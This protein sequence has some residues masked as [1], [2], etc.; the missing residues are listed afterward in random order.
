[1]LMKKFGKSLVLSSF[2][3]LSGYAHANQDVPEQKA[4]SQPE[5]QT[6]EEAPQPSESSVRTDYTIADGNPYNLSDLSFSLIAPEG[7]ETV[8]DNGQLTMVI[9]E[10]KPK[11]SNENREEVIFQRNITVAVMHEASPIDEERAEKLEKQLSEQFGKNTLATNF[12]VLEHRFIDY[13][14]K[15]DAILVYSSLNIGEHPMMQMHLLVSSSNKQFLLT[16]TD[17]EK[18]FIEDK[19]MMEAVW[20]SMVSI[21]I[22]GTAPSRYANAIKL[23]VGGLAGILL[24]GLFGFARRRAANAALDGEED[25]ATD[26][27]FAFSGTSDDAT[28]LESDD[29]WADDLPASDLEEDGFSNHAV[30]LA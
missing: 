1:M 27:D 14:G 18:R 22:N 11:F 16:F 26:G 10:P 3:V 5:V 25:F 24:L 21:N 29:D 15:K 9:Q 4:E 23:G 30:S 17:L 28:F 19:P 8:T 7:W 20:N 13:K 6:Q 2:V 12:Q